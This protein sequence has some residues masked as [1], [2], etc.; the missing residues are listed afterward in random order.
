[1]NYFCFVRMTKKE[2]LEPVDN[3]ALFQKYQERVQIK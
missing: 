1:M 3:Y 2:H